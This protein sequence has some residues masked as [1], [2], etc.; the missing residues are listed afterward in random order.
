MLK[1][2]L[3]FILLFSIAGAAMAQKEEQESNLKAAFI[4]NFTRYIDWD[5]NTAETE[6]IIGII[7][8]SVVDKAI[9]EIVKT[10]TVNN[11][12]IVIRHFSKPEDISYCHILFIPGNNPSPL[13][14]IL[15]KI[16][17]GVLT[18]SERPGFAKMGTAFNFLLVNDKLKF[19]AS[20]KAI[21]QA[22]LKAS[23]QL[24]KLAIIVN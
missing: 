8:S 9:S 4:Y 13:S 10:N 16:D 5:N 17:K 2:F 22:G 6:F 19:E 21:N 14:S 3:L 23:S 24:L 11:K 1:R 18:V 20:L 15:D 7:G 12:R